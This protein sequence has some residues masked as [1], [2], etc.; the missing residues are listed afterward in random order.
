MKA[1]TEALAIR[2]ADTI[3]RRQYKL[4]AGLN[5]RTR[6]WNRGRQLLALI[7]F[8]LLFGGACAWLL[9]RSFNQ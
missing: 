6:H 9:I 1:K 7:L 8:V 3:L 2:I 5:R 4:A